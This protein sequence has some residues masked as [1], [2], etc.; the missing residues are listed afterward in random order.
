MSGTWYPN[1]REQLAAEL[2]PVHSQPVELYEDEVDWEAA[3]G[4]L[5]RDEWDDWVASLR[6][7]PPENDDLPAWAS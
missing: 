3:I 2:R 7:R 6:D 1:L 4:G 5:A